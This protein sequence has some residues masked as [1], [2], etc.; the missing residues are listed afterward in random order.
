MEGFSSWSGNLAWGTFWEPPPPQ[1]KKLILLNEHDL[2]NFNSHFSSSFQ[3]P[4]LRYKK[5]CPSWQTLNR[6]FTTDQKMSEDIYISHATYQAFPLNLIR[7]NGCCVGFQVIKTKGTGSELLEALLQIRPHLTPHCSTVISS[8]LLPSLA[9]CS[10]V[11]SNAWCSQS[12]SWSPTDFTGSV[13]DSLQTCSASFL[14]RGKP[15]PPSLQ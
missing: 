7:M 9:V 1:K 3:N 15:V 14:S 8:A 10:L 6:G 2:T 13:R 5:G 4:P 11:C 12:A